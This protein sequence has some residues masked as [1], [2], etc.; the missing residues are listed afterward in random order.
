VAAVCVDLRGVTWQGVGVVR[1][2]RW[3]LT[4]QGC[5]KWAASRAGIV[6]R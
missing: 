2:R 5:W 4:W 3:V 1:G 6:G